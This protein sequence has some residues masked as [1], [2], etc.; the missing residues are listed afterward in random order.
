MRKCKG[1]LCRAN[2]LGGMSLPTFEIIVFLPSVEHRHLALM[3]NM[4][5][6]IWWLPDKPIYANKYPLPMFN[7]KSENVKK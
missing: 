4:K 2:F 1:R 5:L 7:T 6:F 3:T